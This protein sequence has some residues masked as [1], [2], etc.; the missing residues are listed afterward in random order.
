ML[1]QKLFP[2]FIAGRHKSIILNLIAS[3]QT[4]YVPGRY[5]DDSIR[6][7]SDL[8]EYIDVQNLPGLSFFELTT[9]FCVLACKSQV[10][11]IF[12]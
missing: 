7:T 2:K 9:H 5:I 11:K 1:A 10:L 6:L 12:S 4:A 3:D 8:L